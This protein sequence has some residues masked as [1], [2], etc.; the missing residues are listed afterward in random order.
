MDLKADRIV[1]RE[2]GFVMN[3]YKE[4]QAN[5]LDRSRKVLDSVPE[6]AAMQWVRMREYS[7]LDF[8]TAPTLV[9]NLRPVLRISHLRCYTSLREI[10]HEIIDHL[11]L[12]D[13]LDETRVMLRATL[14]FQRHNHRTE[15]YLKPMAQVRQ[16]AQ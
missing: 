10:F 6:F 3:T 2:A 16:I 12:G 13:A 4:V 9:P 15:V 7:F 11:Q 14:N 8:S 5:S 1:C